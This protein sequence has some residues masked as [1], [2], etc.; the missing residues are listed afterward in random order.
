[1]KIVVTKGRLRE[2]G[3][4][5]GLRVID[6][7]RDKEEIS[8]LSGEEVE[9]EARGDNLAY[10]IYT[11]GSTGTPKGVEVTHR[12]VLRLVCNNYYA[13]FDSRQVFYQYAPV[14]FDASTF[15]IWGSLC[16][17][18][19]LVVAE[20]GNLSVME[21]GKE[22][23]EKGVTTLWLTAGL[24]HEMV[25]HNVGG[26]G[27]V[28]Q[29]LTGGDVVG[30]G[31]VEKVRREVRGIK[32]IN[33]Y[34]PTESTTFASSYEVGAEEEI[35]SSVPIGRAIGNTEL[36]I[37]DEW[38]EP[39]PVGVVGE[40]FIAGDGLARGYVRRADQTADR[41][42]PNPF[43]TDSGER[44]YRTGDQCR[45]QVD[46]KIEYLGRSDQQVKIRGYRIELGE[47]EEVL[48][49]AE[50]VKE[51]VVVVREDEVIGK[52]IVGYVVME[53]EREGWRER[54]S[55]RLEERLPKYMVPRVYVKMEAMPLN[56]NGKVD[57]L[58]LSKTELQDRQPHSRV[59]ARTPLEE[60]L[61]GIWSQILDTDQFG[62]ADS[63][64]DLGG[65]S[66]IAMR[67]ISKV[68]EAFRIE[69]NLRDLFD[70]PTFAE[71]AL[72]VDTSTR[73]SQRIQLPPIER[74]SRDVEL[75]LSYSQQ[76]LWFIHHLEPDNLAYNIPRAIHIEGPLDSA[77]LERTLIE[78]TRRHES[79]RTSF[80]DNE[81]RPVQ[82]INPESNL[83]LSMTDLSQLE[84]S[85]Q[86]S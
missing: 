26:L 38:L 64:F 39:V 78:I 72:K 50:E 42:M 33:G 67:L 81:G 56:A 41:F 6:L 12:A 75:P 31:D 58:S 54:L 53:E 71:F 29:L 44:M 80:P 16:N 83:I 1:V 77:L 63:F 49:G 24:M 65:H 2:E 79:L 10:V 62:P 22:L 82:I 46:G 60:I 13:S 66:L 11:S 55:R 45:Y 5:M 17:G 36:Y 86:M 9:Q 34:G 25:E 40:L 68:R 27:G 20:A 48:R 70:S 61:I 19:K 18:C 15:E 57:R 85:V 32:V 47:I 73:E 28:K 84:A 35:G 30:V 14:S 7:E 76:R 43:A 37:L 59:V 52:Q 8:K 3:E 21:I 69:L 51:A 4:A 23:L 74:V